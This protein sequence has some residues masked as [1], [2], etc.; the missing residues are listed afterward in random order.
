MVTFQA[1]TARLSI[2]VCKTLIYEKLENVLSKLHIYGYHWK[3]HHQVKSFIYLFFLEIKTIIHHRKT[4]SHLKLH[5]PEEISFI[6]D[7]G[8]KAH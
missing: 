4:L 2:E 8:Y 3:V 1:Q 6:K 5:H 7:Y